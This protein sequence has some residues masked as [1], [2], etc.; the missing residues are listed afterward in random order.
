M[1]SRSTQLDSGFRP[2][3]E[4][5]DKRGRGRAAAVHGPCTR[6][7]ACSA[8]AAP[9]GARRPA[10]RHPSER[11]TGRTPQTD[12]QR[13][14]VELDVRGRSVPGCPAVTVAAAAAAAGAVQAARGGAPGRQ[15][16]CRIGRRA[17]PRLR[18]PS[19]YG[20]PG[21]TIPLQR[22]V[23]CDGVADAGAGSCAAAIAFGAGR[24]LT[25]RACASGAPLASP[26]RRGGVSAAHSQPPARGPADPPS[27]HPDGRPGPANVVW[28]GEICARD[29]VM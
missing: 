25:A 24:S 28:G 11:V 4:E 16:A 23:E 19:E 6:T 5:D 2:R 9:S 13:T 15:G 20:A 8:R 22:C 1:R 3:G 12:A 7:R 27:T 29:D 17:G 18:H 14:S 21:A 26:Q 10:A